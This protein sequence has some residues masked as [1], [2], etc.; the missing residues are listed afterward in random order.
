M[1]T[2]LNIHVYQSRNKKIFGYLCRVMQ[3]LPF[4]CWV[5]WRNKVSRPE[6]E[7]LQL[8]ASKLSFEG[9]LNLCD[10]ARH[11]PK[12]IPCVVN[13]ISLRYSFIFKIFESFPYNICRCRWRTSRCM[14]S[15]Q[16]HIAPTLSPQRACQDI[17]VVYF[18][19][20]IIVLYYF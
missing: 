5:S 8:L 4:R 16:K 18:G 19:C 15:L 2:N 11:V 7:A 3:L 9:L 6:D 12:N 20:A 14:W 17:R 10:A 1:K 13:G